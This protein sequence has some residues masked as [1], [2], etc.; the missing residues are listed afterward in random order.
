MRRRAA[1]PRPAPSRAAAPPPARP[2]RWRGRFRPAAARRP[3][4]R[5]HR[6]AARRWARRAPRRLPRARCAVADRRRTSPAGRPGR[7]TRTTSP[8]SGH[9]PAYA[10]RPIRS[11]ACSP[12][13]RA[14]EHPHAGDS[15][16]DGPLAHR[17]EHRHSRRS[18]RPCIPASTPA[19]S[20]VRRA[21][22][23]LAPAITATAAST[24]TG[25]ADSRARRRARQ[26]SPRP[27]RREPREGPRRAPR[28]RGGAGAPGRPR[29]PARRPHA[30]HRRLARAEPRLG[31]R[32][33]AGA[34]R[35]GRAPGEG[36][37]A[38]R[39]RAQTRTCSRRAARRFS[40]MPGIWSSS[41]TA[42]K[43]PCSSRKSRILGRGRTDAV[44]LSSC[45]S[46]AVLRFS[47]WPGA[48][49]AEGVGPGAAGAALTRAGRGPGDRPRPSRPG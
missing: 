14:V 26:A 2:G 41:S 9:A 16:P 11:T 30:A 19:S 22:A 23:R 35:A 36:A 40:P 7:A 17:L 44:E 39:P 31:R 42:P 13:A 45:S 49:A 48:S 6:R 25:P 33:G 47:G 21:S 46:V 38:S 24:A 29:G 20:A 4:S 37:P 15:G 8:I 43:P 28:G 12:D 27:R 10:D 5:R 32:G 18:T 1:R 3:A 34:E